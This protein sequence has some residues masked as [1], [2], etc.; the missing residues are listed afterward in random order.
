MDQKPNAKIDLGYN[1]YP[2]CKDFSKIRD[3]VKNKD[4]AKA[5]LDKRTKELIDK[6][7]NTFPTLVFK[8]HS[9]VDN[10][11]QSS[12]NLNHLRKDVRNLLEKFRR[13]ENHFNRILNHRELQLKI[14]ELRK[15]SVKRKHTL[16]RSNKRY[17]VK[18]YNENLVPVEYHDLYYKPFNEWRFKKLFKKDDKKELHSCQVKESDNKKK[19]LL[20]SPCIHKDIFKLKEHLNE[21]NFE[22]ILEKILITPNTHSILYNNRNRSMINLSKKDSKSLYPKSRM[23]TSI[24]S[25]RDH[26]RIQTSLSRRRTVEATNKNQI[27]EINLGVRNCLNISAFSVNQ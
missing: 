24:G 21:H 15:G 13:C 19:I 6:K 20:F 3:Y 5:F 22:N 25:P 4:E 9:A 1:F 14:N 11:K 23:S 12:R 16:I 26:V 17:K 10:L 18:N 7:I 2:K 27:E 8:L